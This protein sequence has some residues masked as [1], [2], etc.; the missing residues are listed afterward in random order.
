VN[1]F[2]DRRYFAR[3]HESGF[4]AGPLETVFRLTRLLGQINERFGF[5]ARPTSPTDIVSSCSSSSA[6]SFAPTSY[7]AASSLIEWV[8]TRRSF[9][10]CASEPRRSRSVSGRAAVRDCDACAIAFRTSGVTVEDFEQLPA[11]RL[12]L[13]RQPR[14]R[15]L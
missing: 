14:L 10:D 7:P 5:A 12:A 4:R 15:E 1:G 11:Y 9:G 13:R 3:A 8:R 2:P 6:A